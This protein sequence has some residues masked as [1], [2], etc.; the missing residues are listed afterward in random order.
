MKGADTTQTTQPPAR[1]Q[2]KLDLSYSMQGGRTL[3]SYAHQGPL[4]V[5]QSLYPEGDAV[6]HQV[7][8][9]PPGGLVGG[10]QIQIDVRVGCGAHAFVTT[11]GATRFYRSA[12]PTASQHIR[13]VLEP[14]ARLEWL[15]LE[16]IAYSGCRAHNQLNLALAPGAQA[17]AWDV[18]VLGL[19]ESGQP[20]EQG[21]FLQH[22]EVEGVWLDRGQIHASDRRLLD[23]PVG[24]AG[25]RC[26]A[27]LILASG[28]DWPTALIEQAQEKARAQTGQGIELGVTLAHP[29][30]LVARVLSDQAEPARET[31][32]AIWADWRA[33]CWGLHPQPSRMWRV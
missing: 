20:F 24:L 21:D 9:H 13:V 25:R 27:T 23:G 30:V 22:M 16:T 6:C 29:K 26:L 17:M 5:L 4:R 1:W 3:A 2:A 18:L 19:P 12:G 8:V 32:Q 28:D 15:P 14:N 11:P 31:L 10:D 33:L 7:L